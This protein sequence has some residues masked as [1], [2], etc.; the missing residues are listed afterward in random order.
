MH[1]PGVARPGA[2]DPLV[3]PL[4]LGPHRFQA[5]TRGIMSVVSMAGD[6]RRHTHPQAVTEQSEVP[7]RCRIFGQGRE[8]WNRGLRELSSTIVHKGRLT[9]LADGAIR[10]TGLPSVDLRLSP[11]QAE[12][13]QN[14]GL[15][16]SS[17][18]LEIE[19]DAAAF[20]KALASL[21][22]PA[23]VIRFDR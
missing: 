3:L 17:S 12:R 10:L 21:P 4:Q 1:L 9:R 23:D 22:R 19:I 2:P 11:A 8:D 18:N 7:I 15:R 13:V 14:D 16:L 20:R 6:S 5:F